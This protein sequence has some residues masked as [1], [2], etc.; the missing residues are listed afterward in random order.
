MPSLGGRVPQGNISPRLPRSEGPFQCP[1]WADGSRRGIAISNWRRDEHWFQCPL[2]ADG[3]RRQVLSLSLPLLR[4]LFQCPL[5]AD[6]SRRPGDRDHRGDRRHRFNALFGRTGPAGRRYPCASRPR[7]RFNALLGRTGPAGSRARLRVRSW[8]VPGFNALFGRTGPAG[9]RSSKSPRPIRA[10]FNALFG[11]TG[12]AGWDAF[13]QRRMPHNVSMP[14]L[15]GRVPQ[16]QHSNDLTNSVAMFQ[17]PLWADGSRRSPA[18]HRRP[19]LDVFQCPLW[20]DGSRRS[21]Q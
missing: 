2:W 18:G 19:I 16:V 9:T 10:C 8:L 15:G 20:A 5:W 17:C 1:L 7:R 21:S 12:P 14:S 4:R 6:G 11:R 3:S 13:A